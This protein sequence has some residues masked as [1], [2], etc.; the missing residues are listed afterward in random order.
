MNATENDL[1]NEMTE[2]AAT[3]ENYMHPVVVC[4]SK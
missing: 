2:A 1:R 3:T 4:S